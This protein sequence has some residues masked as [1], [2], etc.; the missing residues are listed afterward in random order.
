MKQRVE[1]VLIVGWDGATLDLVEPWV[2]QGHLPV[3]AG[4][5]RRGSYAPLRSVYPVLSSAAWSSFMTGLNPGKH[6]IYDFV[7]RDPTTYQLRPVSR[8]QMHGRSLWRMASDQGLR[9]GVINVPMTYPPEPVNGFLISGL[10]T[11]NYQPFTYPLELGDDLLRSGYRVNRRV[12]HQG[13]DGQQA[14]LD[15]TYEIS[16]HLTASALQL[17]GEQPWDLFVVVY[18][19]SDEVAHQ[20]W[21]YMDETHPVHDPGLAE[22]YGTALLE[23]Y[24]RLDASLGR[25]IEAAGPNCA[26]FVVSDHGTGPLY[27]DVF[28]NEWL[29]QQGFLARNRSAAHGLR[30][31]MGRL[32]ITRSNVSRILRA[33]GLERVEHAIKTLLGDAISVLPR[34]SWGDLAEVVDWQKT[35]AYSYGYY[36]QIYL[37]VRGREP[38]GVVSPGAEYEGVRDEI[39]SALQAWR[40][41][42]DG[43]PVVSAVYT[44]EDLFAGPFADRAPD[45]TVVMRNLAYVTRY[46]HEFGRAR[47]EVFTA[48]LTGESGSHRLDGLLVAGGEGLISNDGRAPAASLMD[49]TPT[50][51]HL[52]GLPI[53]SHVDGRVLTAYLAAEWRAR[54]ARQYDD[55]G[56]AQEESAKAVLGRDEE[57][58]VVDRLRHLG[59]L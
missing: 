14:F 55:E 41:P 21:S 1:R 43:E 58:E 24:Q 57:E 51:L 20:F 10:G 56:W 50:A 6:G 13:E 47:G 31:R 16:D 34:D 37:N 18:R 25:L 2:E 29:S 36:G 35:R 19:D 46:G 38:S 39:I 44:R 17:M 26:V 9:V 22:S 42:T 52:L 8:L 5:M 45:L 27:R 32:G 30:A 23:C 53:P 12:F 3:L 40:S 15:D 33:I 48:P 28:L 7:I 11:P 4:L 54:E 59:Y 49:I